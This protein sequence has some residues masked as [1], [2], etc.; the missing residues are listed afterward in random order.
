MLV[1]VGVALVCLMGAV[2]AQSPA[3]AVL[4]VKTVTSARVEAG[5]L[6]N[7]GDLYSA[8]RLLGQRARES[9]NVELLR[10]WAHLEDWYGSAGP[11]AY[12]ALAGALS[13]GGDTGELIEVC[14]RGLEVSLREE[15][16]DTARQFAAKLTALGENREADLLGSNARTAGE[17]V[18]ILGG[19]DALHFLVLGK[20]KTNP[21]RV[22]V[23]LS[24]HLA[25]MYAGSDFQRESQMIRRYFE[26]LSAMA[27]LGRRENDHVAVVLS[28]S[29]SAAKQR[30]QKLFNILGLKIRHLKGRIAIEAAE[31]KSQV[32][33][34]DTVA[35]LAVDEGGIEEALAAGRAYEL[36]IP[37][38][39]VPAFPDFSAWKRAFPEHAHGAGGLIELLASDR[40]A[41]QLYVALNV[42]DRTSADMLVKSVSLRTLAERYS[43]GLALFSSALAI[44]GG[45][46]E[47]PGGLS[48]E[49]VW[50]QLC[51]ISPAAPVS[52]FEALLNR[53]DGRLLAFFYTL[54]QLD[55][56]HQRFFTR[57]IDR[58][59]KFYTL[60]RESP[61]MHASGER[62]VDSS[63]FLEFLREVPLNDDGTVNFPGGPEVWMVAKGHSESAASV[64]KLTR[65]LAR[66]A[67]PDDEDAI[68]MRLARTA[69]KSQAGTSSELSNFV[70]VARIDAERERRL[71]AQEA[72]LLAQSYSTFGDLYPYFMELGDLEAVDYQAIFALI[73]K[74]ETFD[75]ATANMRFGELHSFFAMLCIAKQ[76]RLLNPKDVAAVL[77]NGI[78]RYTKASDG[79]AWTLASL[80]AIDDLAGFARK[81]SG[82]ASRDDEI[83]DLLA[84][85]SRQG[86]ADPAYSREKA[87]REVLAVQKVPRLDALFGIQAALGKLPGNAAGIK[88]IEEQV[89]AFD[90]MSAATPVA[91]EMRRCLERYKTKDAQATI[92]KL[93]AKLQ[94]RKRNA[95]EI[96]TVSSE[97]LAELE[98]WAELA[99]AGQIYARYLDASDVLVSED[100]LLL[101]KHE[102][103]AIEAGT[104]KR[105]WLTPA[106]LKTSNGD[107]GSYFEGG[108]ADF[109]M[110]AG[111]ARAV[112]NH[113]GGLNG[114]PF[115]A[116]V[117]A[118]IRATDWRTLRASELQGFAATVRLTREWII[119]SATSD[120]MLMSIDQQSRG[121]V[122]LTRRKALIE[123][124]RMRDWPSVW[125]S[126][127]ISELYFLGN[128]LIELAPRDIWSRQALLAMRQRAGKLGDLQVLGQVAPDLSGCGAPHLRRYDPYEDY[129]RHILPMHLAERTAEIKLRLAWVADSAAWKPDTLAA[130]A[131][132]AADAAMK[133]LELRDAWDWEGA[134]AAIRSLRAENLENFLVQ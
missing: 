121:L 84:G 91:G 17:H 22:L 117:F 73:S 86:S 63:S 102:F 72:L 35:A 29:D 90:V 33:K 113:I 107:G 133:H 114:E 67:A 40:R 74:V 2:F 109:S 95:V 12:L 65:K 85:S 61:Q 120:A 25:S 101:R 106:V 46:A 7:L 32:N 99:M 134:L 51:G 28:L 42:M 94:K 3:A 68:L 14:R 105:R 108:F 55:S 131:G 115:A 103:I 118:S 21:E 124:I 129:E 111:H 58:T 130:I 31:G 8:R 45:R 69:Y 11:Q 96:E 83:R 23:D 54:S 52:F 75:L 122:S 82:S 89:S 4:P 24:R 48:A 43:A 6:E 125:E 71:S 5:S 97:L 76:S 16:F 37:I 123:G 44:T 132:P 26:R 20:G 119:E 18:E 64:S 104:G 126:V 93:R 56:E 81:Q 49:S 57:S 13:G 53:D 27:A 38:D 47:V 10:R 92:S 79:A 112:G 77:R 62:R 87:Y 80:S 1:R 98:P 41:A 66:T 19:V 15:Q 110:A 127:S 59:K 30:T 78:E 36:D 88:E 100:P 39:Q 116:A 9:N 128:S 50:Q 60:F 34:Q 70:A